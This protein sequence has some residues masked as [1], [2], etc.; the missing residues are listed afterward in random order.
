MDGLQQRITYTSTFFLLR[1]FSQGIET[2]CTNQG[3]NIAIVLW[4]ETMISLMKG[5]ISMKCPVQIPLSR[6]DA[7][8]T[9]RLN[10]ASVH[11]QERIQVPSVFHYMVLGSVVPCLGDRHFPGGHLK[12]QSHCMHGPLG[13]QQTCSP[14]STYYSAFVTITN[15]WENKLMKRKGL[16]WLTVLEVSVRDEAV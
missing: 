16:F 6:Q 12:S 9:E 15:T 5:S 10:Q 2:L 4:K 1:E 14:C 11:P 8:Q 7:W 13:T 3:H